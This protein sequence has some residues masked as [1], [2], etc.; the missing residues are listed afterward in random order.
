[1]ELS[2]NVL[3]MVGFFF[4]LAVEKQEADFTLNLLFLFLLTYHENLLIYWQCVSLH[5]KLSDC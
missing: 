5:H 3:C 4:F 2:H 1:M